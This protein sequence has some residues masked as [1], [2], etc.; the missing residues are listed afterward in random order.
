MYIDE[1]MALNNMGGEKSFYIELMK[2]CLE[3]EEE[4][5]NNI[6]SSFNEEDWKDYVLHIHALR[7]GM[8][9]LGIKELA[10]VAEMQETAYKEGKID[11]M[12]QNHEYL[13]QEFEEAHDSI[14][15]YLTHLSI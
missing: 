13:M 12:I 15:E 1:E 5:R 8:L 3:L 11:E 14:R 6:N 9:S 4:R 2:Y 10:S 7:G